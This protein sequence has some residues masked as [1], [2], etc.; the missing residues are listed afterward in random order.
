MKELYKTKLFIF[1][2]GSIYLLGALGFLIN[3]T[4]AQMAFQLSAVVIAL[5]FEV[6]AKQSK[7]KTVDEYTNNKSLTF[8]FIQLSVLLGLIIAFTVLIIQ[9]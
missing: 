2:N 8:L 7:D 3:E 9:F 6:I 4:I 5:T 1:L